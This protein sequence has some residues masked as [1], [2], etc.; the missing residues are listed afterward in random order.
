M[1][2]DILVSIIIP[3][4]NVENYIEKCIESCVFQTYK[5]IEI[6]VVN[7]GS[8]D[9]TAIICEQMRQ[10]YSNIVYINQD[11][12]GVSVAR[13]KALQICKGDYC[14]FLDSDDWLENDA[15]ESLLSE[16]N[17]NNADLVISECFFV[18]MDKEGILVKKQQGIGEVNE[19]VDADVI[20]SYV[21]LSSKYKLQSSCYKLFRLSIIRSNSLRFNSQIHFGEDGLFTYCY[22]CNCSTV[23]YINKPLWNILDRP[24]SATKSSFSSKCISSIDA[25][26]SMIEYRKVNKT[27]YR[28]LRALRG[29]RAMW[30]M[31]NCIRSHKNEENRSNIVK[32]M[33][34]ILRKDAIYLV[35]RDLRV[36]LLF[37]LI[38]MCIF[39]TTI[40]IK[41]I[42]G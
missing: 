2:N 33:R 20:L 36:K 39:P 28:N 13:N 5:N 29:E 32:D 26:N 3:A 25:V 1:K 41:M 27:I 9:N 42:R 15:I 37:Q 12:Q 16:Q 8:S 30:V 14:L 7:D 34:S 10:T 19:F 21:G 24:G 40:M 31:I 18:E 35:K 11:N 4:Y 38:V 22:L 6:I 17:N 23:S